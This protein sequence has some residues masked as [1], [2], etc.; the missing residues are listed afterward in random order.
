VDL[1]A[2]GGGDRLAR[3]DHLERAAKPAPRKLTVKNEAADGGLPGVNEDV[4]RVVQAALGM[5]VE[6]GGASG[7]GGASAPSLAV[8]AALSPLGGAACVVALVDVA[9]DD[10]EVQEVEDRRERVLTVRRR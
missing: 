9:H 2:V 6:L 7:G 3:L 10:G 8:G 1:D 5:R 4:E